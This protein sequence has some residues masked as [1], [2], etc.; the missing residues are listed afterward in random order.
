[1]SRAVTAQGGGRSG[2][3]GSRAGSGRAV[4]TGVAAA[5][6]WW[7]QLAAGHEL[8]QWTGGWDG[9]GSSR[10][11]CSKRKVGMGVAA[12]GRA[13]GRGSGR[14]AS[15]WT[16]CGAVEGCAHWA[17]ELPGGHNWTLFERWYDADQ[18][19]RVEYGHRCGGLCG[20]V[21]ARVE[22]SDKGMA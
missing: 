11:S 21:G 3:Q 19:Y 16:G 4:K 13:A 17:A 15:G 18:A 1:M 9:S 14:V 22:C 5:A 10:G 12:A 20:G 8:N 6:A 7:Q 2:R